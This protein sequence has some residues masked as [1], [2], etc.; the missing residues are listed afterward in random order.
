MAGTR[1]TAGAASPV[2]AREEMIVGTK[3]AGVAGAF[4]SPAAAITAMPPELFLQPAM[5]PV[6]TPVVIAD[7][8]KFID[9]VD[10]KDLGDILV[11]PTKSVVVSQNPPPGEQVPLGT[12]V[13]ITLTVK[14]TIPLQPLGV[15]DR[16]ATKWLT[17]GGLT[18]AVDTSPNGDEVKDLL[19]KNTSYTDLSTADKTVADGFMAQVG[20][21]ND[22][23]KS[24]VF[25]DLGFLFNL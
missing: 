1:K 3:A 17:V 18:E 24:K 22:A 15:D 19:A 12:S 16:V 4:A 11:R 21:L 2:G 14:D 6:A 25:D 7:N 8:S 10:V 5:M 13:T 9:R 20:D 23:D